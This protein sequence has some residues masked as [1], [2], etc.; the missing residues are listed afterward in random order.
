MAIPEETR[1]EGSEVSLDDSENSNAAGHSNEPPDRT[2]QSGVRDI[3]ATTVAWTTNALIFA[4]VMLWIT[5]FVEGMLGGVTAALNPYVTSAFA[6]HSLTPTVGVLSSVIG[7]VTNLTLAKILDVFGRPQGYLFCVSLATVGLIMMAACNSVES[8]A[9]AQVFYTVGNNGL[10]YSLSVFVADTSKLR[11]RGLM[12]AIVSTPNL[13]TCWLAGPIS[14][15][16]LNG[17]GWR[18][19]FGMFTILVPAVALPL[20]GLLLKNYFKAKNLGLISKSNSQP[21]SLQSV[22]HYCCE[23]DAIGLLLISAGF[24]LF[25]LPFDLYTLQAKGWDSALVISML[26]IGVA[27]IITFV[28]WEKFFVSTTFMPYSLLLDRTVFGACILSATLF[29]S[30]YCWASFLGSFLQVVNGLSVTDA[31]YV[32]Q[33]YTVCSVLCSVGVGAFIHYT[34]RF[35]PVCLYVGMPLSILGVGLMINFLGPSGNIGYIVMCQIFLSVGSGIVVI[36]DEIAIL[37]AASHQ[38]TAVCIAVL[39]M[40][41]S[42]GG[43]IGLT[44]ASAIWQDIFPKKLADY[45]PAKDLPDL[46]LIYA[47]LSTQLSYPMGSD[48]RL[49]IQHAY[50][51]AQKMLLTAGTAVWVAGVIGVL[52][53]RNINVIGIRQTKGHVW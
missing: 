31:S 38:H 9:A 49:A 15:G 42:V 46:L 30:Y 7:G 26:V 45:L 20:W 43:A 12:Q 1:I 27:L 28:I 51:D 5:Y 11:N 22:L 6:L 53:W 33:T 52:L 24:A 21:N 44:I 50:A 17:P 4:Y 34:G 18:W 19:A 23:F 2:A 10:Q 3:E 36:C 25:L 29:I 16:F 35:K 47:D 14:T 37:A 32:Q 40:F 41:A 39:S 48:T 13:I 8:Y